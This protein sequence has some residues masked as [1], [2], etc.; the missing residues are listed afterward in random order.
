[1]LFMIDSPNTVYMW[2]N[3][4]LVCIASIVCGEVIYILKRVWIKIG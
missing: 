4:F 2:M 1:M 3:P